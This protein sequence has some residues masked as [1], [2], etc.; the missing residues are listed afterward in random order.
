MFGS[1]RQ[2]IITV[3]LII[4]A[5]CGLS[6]AL[7]SPD[8]FHGTTAKTSNPATSSD[9]LLDWL[10]PNIE[11]K[12]ALGW[13][14]QI[15][16]A[17]LLAQWGYPAESIRILE[18]LLTKNPQEPQV[19][20]ML[21]ALYLEM[22]QKIQ[23]EALLSNMKFTEVLQPVVLY[24]EGRLALWRNRA[25]QAR[26]R[27]EA[28]LMQISSN[29]PLQ[30]TL[31]FYR[32]YTLE[33]LGRVEAFDVEINNALEA[34][35]IAKN[36]LE[37]SILARFY[38]RNN[39]APQAI[40]L[41]ERGLEQKTLADPYYLQLLADAY[42][43]A[44]LK[45][46]AL[47]TYTAAINA[48]GTHP[49]LFLKHANL[50]RYNGDFYAAWQSFQRAMDLGGSDA[51]LYFGAGINALETG[52]IDQAKI[53]LSKASAQLPQHATAHYLA[54]FSAYLTDDL[55]NA[56][57]KLDLLPDADNHPL[58][59]EVAL[60]TA[61]IELTA[62][63]GNFTE[64]VHAV[65]TKISNQPNVPGL[66]R[67]VL[68]QNLCAQQASAR[69]QPKAG[70]RQGKARCALAFWIGEW[71]RLQGQITAATS[72]YENA[73]SHGRTDFL[74]YQAASWRLRNISKKS[75]QQ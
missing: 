61:F 65:M 31:L 13:Q 38:L 9:P 52:H 27:F 48:G 53:Y 22:D 12:D 46:L 21:A 5:H 4:H 23:V 67:D 17:K 29:D 6:I 63:A 10:L 26:S 56:R 16:R 44:N 51:A 19:L 40:V 2:R 69:L 32:A 7:E 30:P 75:L 41:L 72:Y 42:F 64:K 70:E 49:Q 39:G 24:L 20:L 59:D 25:G 62:T 3:V 37:R 55:E 50:L 35:F 36:S 1:I 66:L 74:E 18:A 15:M 33:L 11:P 73:L 54:A 47:E 34:G 43:T 60:L 68:F 71:Y 14:T 57:L 8:A 58:N 45:V 28:A